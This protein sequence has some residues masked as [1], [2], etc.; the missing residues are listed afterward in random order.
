MLLLLHFV[1][2]TAAGEQLLLSRQGLTPLTSTAAHQFSR[3][4]TY[5]V[6]ISTPI[7]I[8]LFGNS[9]VM[10]WQPTLLAAVA[11]A[12]ITHHTMLLP[13]SLST[14]LQPPWPVLPPRQVPS[15]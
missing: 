6:Q 5:L 2:M 1:V 3:I 15:C 7:A 9:P 13:L 14:A 12:C 4:T 11:A 10:Q 8:Q